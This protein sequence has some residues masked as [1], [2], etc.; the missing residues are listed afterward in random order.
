MRA[1]YVRA[2]CYENRLRVHLVAG[3]E[4]SELFSALS[5][6]F[7]LVRAIYG[8]GHINIQPKCS[9]NSVERSSI[10]TM[11]INKPKAPTWVEQ[12]AIYICIFYFYRGC[13][14]SQPN[15]SDGC[16]A[17][18][19]PFL[20]ITRNDFGQSEYSFMMVQPRSDIASQPLHTQF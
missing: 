5:H 11:I 18:A 15:E 12:F 3:S 2:E 7:H 17:A 6:Y 16:P 8:F 4:T 1:H 13:N 9:F 20:A 14:H 19:K 10:T